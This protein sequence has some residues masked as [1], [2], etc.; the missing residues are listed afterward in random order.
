MQVHVPC[1]YAVAG[2][3]IVVSLATIGST[4]LAQSIDRLPV[5]VDTDLGTDIDDAFALALIMGSHELDLRGVTTVGGNTRQKAMMACRFLTMTGRRSTPVAIG[6]DPQVERPIASQYPY[7]YHPDVLF[8]RTKKP[9]A[10]SA[11]D[12]LYGRLKGQPGRITV[13]ALGPLTN[14]ARLIREKPDSAAMIGRIV[15]AENKIAFDITAAKDV[16]AAGVPLVIL[17]RDATEG[18]KLEAASVRRVL[19]PGTPLTRQ[20]EALY[21]MWNQEQPPLADVLTATICF[22]DKFARFAERSLRI[23]D[24]GKLV[25]H[26]GSANARVIVALDRDAFRTWYVDRTSSLVPPER[27]PSRL[28]ER[29]PMPNRVHVAEDYDTDIERRWWMSGKPETKNLPTGSLRACRS[30]L[31]HDFDDLLMVSRQMY[32]AVIFNPVPGPAMGKQTRLSFRYWLKGT[33]TLRVQIYS[34]T[35]GY[36]R[37]LV[38]RDLPQERWQLATVDMTQARRPDGS[39]GPLSENERIDDIQFYIDPNAEV[40]IDDIVLYD[41]ATAGE[42]RPFPQRILYTGQFDTGKQG[43]E[44]PGNFEIVPDAGN[45]WR[46]ARSIKNDDTG[47]PWIRLDLRGPRT[48]G[49]KTQLHFRYRLTGADN[50][51]VQLRNSTAN[52]THELPITS[53]TRDAWTETTLDFSNLIA[54]NGSANGHRANEIHFLCPA[55]AELFIDDVLLFEPGE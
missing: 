53:L 4:S 14:M 7:Y 6:Q 9:E 36:H 13:L 44:W 40:I 45:F 39:G 3:L 15:L 46:A 54:K 22:Q 52:I 31:T 47:L 16:F 51:R 12:F 1:R 32:S 28:V 30:V 38:V 43:Q 29:G 24:A 18:L 41:A 35:N 49:S 27:T 26:N 10:S 33:D 5:L 37:H 23:D 20:V 48:L 8:D 55:D 50:L 2:L 17:P 34:L 25:D 21:Q 11:V 42:S 19:S